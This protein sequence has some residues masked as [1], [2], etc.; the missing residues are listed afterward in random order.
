M[1]AAALKEMCEK[2]SDAEEG[3]LFRLRKENF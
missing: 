2:H 3:T 1:I